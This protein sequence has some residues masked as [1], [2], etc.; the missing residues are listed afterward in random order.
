MPNLP[1][2]AIKIG[3]QVGRT[4]CVAYNCKLD[5]NGDTDCSEAICEC[6]GSEEDCFIV[7]PILEVLQG[8]TMLCSIL[9]GD[10]CQMTLKGLPIAAFTASCE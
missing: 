2:T 4:E 3:G 6:T 1:Q 10:D 9:P 7:N 8:A 5:K